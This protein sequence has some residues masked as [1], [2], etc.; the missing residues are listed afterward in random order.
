MLERP[1]KVVP[2]DPFNVAQNSSSKSI[3]CV[4]LTKSWN[5]FESQF[6][7][8]GNKGKYGNKPL[9]RVRVL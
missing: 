6:H 1:S 2:G 8:T 3:G 4:N 9:S 7:T 5:F